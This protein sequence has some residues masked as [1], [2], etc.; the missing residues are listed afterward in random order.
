MAIWALVVINPPEEVIQNYRNL[1]KTRESYR[2]ELQKIIPFLLK[3]WMAMK[4]VC[5]P[6]SEVWSI[7]NMPCILELMA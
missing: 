4:S 5:G 1:Q 3:P 7:W 6:I 2:T